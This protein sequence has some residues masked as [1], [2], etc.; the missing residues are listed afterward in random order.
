[1]AVQWSTQP[2]A[3]LNQIIQDAIALH[4]RDANS[5]ELRL[6]SARAALTWLS[7]GMSQ[8]PARE[9]LQEVIKEAEAM[10]DQTF[11]LRYL[12]GMNN[13]SYFVDFHENVSHAEL[14]YVGDLFPWKECPEHYGD[15]VLSCRSGLPHQ[16]KLLVQQYLD[17]SVNRRS[18]L[19]F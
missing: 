1:V 7:L 9:A 5:E 10:D 4:V 14:R 13:A 19:A 2:G 16:D 6:S 12:H 11:A 18:R 8:N 3:S 17:F 15:N